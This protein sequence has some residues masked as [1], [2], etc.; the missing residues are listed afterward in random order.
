MRMNPDSPKLFGSQ[1]RIHLV[2]KEIR[3]RLIVEGYM[4]QRAVLFH[5]LQ[6]LHQQ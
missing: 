2:I 3:H 4:S 5:Q 1:T 6:V